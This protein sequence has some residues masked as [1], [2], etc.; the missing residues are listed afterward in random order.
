MSLFIRYQDS[1][2]LGFEFVGVS[3]GNSNV[4]P[5]RHGKEGS[6]LPWEQSPRKEEEMAGRLLPPVHSNRLTASQNLNVPA[7]EQLVEME[8]QERSE[9]ELPVT[10]TSS[11]GR[12]VSLGSAPRPSLP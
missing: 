11:A 9:A 5:R 1:E 8:F 10:Q 3:Q 4:P 7:P 12:A 6:R 2:S